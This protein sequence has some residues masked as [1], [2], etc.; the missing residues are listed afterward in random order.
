MGQAAGNDYYQHTRAGFVR[1]W[2]A[3]LSAAARR[4]SFHRLIRELRPGPTDLV[5]DVGVTADVGM[6]E[7]NI[8]EQC[9]PH[10]RRLVALGLEPLSANKQRFPEVCFV[11]GDARALPFADRSF[12]VFISNATIEHA[13]TREQQA[14]FVREA[15]RVGRKVVIVTPNRWFPLE[16]HTFIPFL[17]YLPRQWHRWW[18]RQLGF[19]F[20]AHE[21]NLRLL[22]PGDLRALFPPASDVVVRCGLLGTTLVATSVSRQ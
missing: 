15:L 3:P 12:S 1:V 2:L 13:G 10:P 19:T 5:L 21:A 16:L 7:S 22:S 8:F 4:R 9:Y 14:A 17:H 11:Q 18:L 20:Y 6:Q